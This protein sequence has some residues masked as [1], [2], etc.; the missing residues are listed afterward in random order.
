[1][2]L[3]NRVVIWLAI[4]TL[5]LAVDLGRAE[6][7]CFGGAPNGAPET[8]EECDDNNIASGDGCD[9]ECRVETGWLCSQPVDFDNLS[10]LEY[11]GG[12]SN[13]IISP[14][15]WTGTQTVNTATPT[16]ATFGA[17]ATTTT[18]TFELSVQTPN[19]DDFVGFVM[20]FEP[21]DESDPNAEYILLDW[22]QN[23]Q[24]GALRGM[25]LSRVTGVPTAVPSAPTNSD[26][27]NHSGAVS[28]LARAT[29]YGNSGWIDHRV[30]SF[31]ID[32]SLTRIVVRVTD[33]TTHSTVTAFDVTGTFPPGQIGFYG[34]SQREARYTIVAPRGPSVCNRPPVVPNVTRTVRHSSAGRC[35]DMAGGATDPDGDG[36]DPNVSIVAS[37]TGVTTTDP[38][39]GAPPGHVCLVPD[40]TST[41]STFLTTVQV[42]DD[43]PA[44]RGCTDATLQVTF[45][46]VPPPTIDSPD[47][48][49]ATTDRRPGIAGTCETGADVTVRVGTDTVCVATCTGGTYGCTPSTDLPYGPNDLTV[50]QTMEGV[51][52][53][54]SETTVTIVPCIA[55]TSGIDEGCTA[56]L[57]ACLGSGA[58]AVC[59]ECVTTTQCEDGNACTTHACTGNVCVTTPVLAGDPGTCA[60]GSVCSGPGATPANSCVACVD[61]TSGG[62]DP[63][64]SGDAPFC[65]EVGGAP[66]CEVCEDT[67]AGTDI[68][69]TADEPHCVEDNGVLACLECAA[70]SDCDD[71][72]ECTSEACTEGV[73]SNPM[74]PTGESCSSGVC[75]SSAMC[76][77]LE[78]A[79]GQPGDGTTTSNP[80]PRI[81]GTGTPGETV[82]VTIEVSGAHVELGT[83][84]VDAD[85]SWSLAYPEDRA[86]LDDGEHTVTAS[87]IVGSMS[88]DDSSTFTVDTTV[89]ITSPADGSTTGD[90]TPNIRGRGEPGA[91]VV[92]T[93]DGTEIGRTTVDEDGYWVVPV[94]APLDNG[95][96]TAVAV[97]TNE[98][99]VESM[100]TSTF[101]VDSNTT[102][103]IVTPENLST[104]N[105]NRPIISGTA[106][107]GATVTVTLEVDGEEVELG[108]VTADEDGNWSLEYPD[109]RSP[110]D[111]RQHTVTATSTDG[112]GNRGADSSTF[113]IDTSTF[114]EIDSVDPETGTITG[115]GEPGS[116]VTVAVDGMVV[117]S[118]TIGEDG[119]WTLTTD[120]FNQPGNHSVTAEAVDPAGNVAT[121]ES[122]IVVPTPAEDGG[123]PPSD[124]GTDGG[125]LPI[126]GLAG[127]AC[128]VSQSGRGAP[129]GLGLLLL[130]AAVVLRR[131]RRR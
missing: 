131:R 72:N 41:E 28:E 65:R 95:P 61:T 88:T 20:G 50:T 117:G 19:D 49:T 64:C 129:S 33:Q 124:G 47:D 130:A 84:V 114:V 115:R 102:V 37:D 77:P 60:D 70:P 112:D 101:T 73:C 81:E 59:V 90:A 9:D 17:D 55:G 21:G 97:A 71:G 98:G 35:F 91:E 123:V 43:R 39:D 105:D 31:E 69:C 26:F 58:T 93:V 108:T 45:E 92:V 80:R 57:P 13:W 82:V 27:W 51:E 52:S 79:I 32:Y 25:A 24:S 63:G 89:T 85:G 36:I 46:V 94:T 116:T 86:A 67:G 53:A 83:T 8:D 100:A 44:P 78:V 56:A 22:K 16:I 120:P 2:T 15:G 111:E 14:D 6:A 75:T 110:L 127:G 74:R 23:N 7:Q 48:G 5:A 119:V 113:R 126:G 54:E 68:G 38:S 10:T 76:L 18:Y 121:E 4:G 62:T 42:C 107:P 1:M 96:H 30:Y 3:V 87:I 122:S 103:T 29:T 12:N 118:V 11:S 34:F 106:E 128:A 104:L 125:V 109:D 66:Q 40:D 99:G